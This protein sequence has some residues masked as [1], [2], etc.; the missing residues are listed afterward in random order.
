MDQAGLLQIYKNIWLLEFYR[1]EALCEAHDQIFAGHNAAQ[2][3][4]LRL[5]SS[6]FWP[7]VYTHILKHANLSLLPAKETFQNE[8]STACSI[9]HSRSTLHQG[10]CWSIRANVNKVLAEMFEL[11]NV[12]H[13]KTSPYHPKCNAQVKVFNKTVTNILPPMLTN[14][15]LTGTSGCQLSCWHTTPVTIPLLRQRLSNCYLESSPD[16]PS[17]PAPEIKWHHYGKSFAAERLQILQQPAN[18]LGKQQLNKVRNTKIAMTKNQH[19]TNLL[20]ESL[21]QRHHFHR[22]KTLN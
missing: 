20:S 11:L 17:L 13:S 15:C 4:Y 16:F 5:T 22:T 9:T 2:K 1:K 3:T 12:Q 14:Q 6:Y 21:A 8:K 7:N 19:Y 10:S 18:W